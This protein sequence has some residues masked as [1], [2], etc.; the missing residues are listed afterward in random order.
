MKSFL[1][2]TAAFLL[3]S[4]I[5][6]ILTLTQTQAQM[7]AIGTFDHH[8]DIGNPKMKGSTSY[9]E[10]EQTYTMSGAGYNMWGDRDE[11]QF[12]WKKL[13][14]DFIV[15][16]TIQ[17]VGKGEA[18][19]RKIGIMARESLDDNSK[20]ADACVHGDQLT[21]L[22]YRAEVSGET[23]QVELSVFHPTDIELERKG[24]KFIFSAAVFGENYK[25]VTKELDLSEDLY[26]GLFICSHLEDVVEKAIFSNVRIVIPEWEGLVQYRDYLGSNLEVMDIE[27]GHRNILHTAPN[28]LQA[29]NWTPDNKKLIWA[30][31]GLLKYYNLEDGTLGTLNTGLANQNNNDHVLSFDGKMM[32]ISHHVGENR[33]STVYLMPATGSDN[34]EQIT[35]PENGH[36]FLHGFSPDGKKMIYTAQRNNQWDIWQVDIASKEEINLTNNE[37]LDDGSEY[38]PDGKYI[39]FN[40]VRTGTMQIWRMKPD[41]SEQEQITFDEYND[42]FAHFSPDGKW[43][44][45]ISFPADMDPSTHPFY[46]KVYIRLMPAS[47]GVPKTIAYVYG[48]QGTINVPSW[49]PD[50][51]KIAFISN[52]KVE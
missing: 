37:A 26:V 1:R 15:R 4:F 50:S 21:S 27:T 16:A 31:E 2:A 23:E 32:G 9:D 30:E 44:V 51:K 33:T 19:H 52:T 28:S 8:Q 20:Y 14:G 11:F 47:G 45:Y 6:S 10:K 36:S 48:G 39:Y 3:T 41:G 24:N 38:S 43:I 5:V 17:F 46:K 29:P 7:N 18:A 22:Q 12:A 35:K 42:W 25:S 13:K 49:S 34:P 40:S